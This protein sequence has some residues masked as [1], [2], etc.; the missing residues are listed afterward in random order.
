MLDAN[1]VGSRMIMYYSVLR[2]SYIA[3]ERMASLNAPFYLDPG[4][5]RSSLEPIEHTLTGAI[6]PWKKG[7]TY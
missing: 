3:Q 7:T 4:T 6:D 5:R 2:T 1:A